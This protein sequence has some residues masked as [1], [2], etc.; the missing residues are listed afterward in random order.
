MKK[1]IEINPT[2]ESKEITEYFYNTKGNL[3]RIESVDTSKY[4]N[5]ESAKYYDKRGRI[6]EEIVLK[7]GKEEVTQYFYES[8]KVKIENEEGNT[9][10]IFNN[11]GFPISHLTDKEDYTSFDLIY[12]KKGLLQQ[13]KIDG[14]VDAEVKYIKRKK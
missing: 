11:K 6:K 9:T 14:K 8:N 10:V 5:R 7:D 12:D 1:V 3:Q 2:F 4:G 13:I